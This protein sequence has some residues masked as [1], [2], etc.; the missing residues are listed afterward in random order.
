[1][2]KPRSGVKHIKKRKG[3][4]VK[5]DDLKFLKSR[6]SQVPVRV[7]YSW[8]QIFW[9]EGKDTIIKRIKLIAIFGYSGV[10]KESTLVEVKYWDGM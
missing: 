4:F 8:A 10:W 6:W 5:L 9:R 1:M 7:N 3:K 2:P